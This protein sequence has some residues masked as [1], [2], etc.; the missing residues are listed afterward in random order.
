MP[1][2]MEEFGKVAHLFGK[3]LDPPVEIDP[4]DDASVNHFFEVIAPSLPPETRLAI[5]DELLSRQSCKE[6]ETPV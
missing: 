4:N 5:L 3:R 6:A 1:T 2:P